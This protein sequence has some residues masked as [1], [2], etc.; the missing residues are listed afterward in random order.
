[1]SAERAGDIIES[2]IGLAVDRR[3]WWFVGTLMRLS[4]QWE[5]NEE[6]VFDPAIKTKIGPSKDWATTYD[7]YIRPDGSNVWD[8][9]PPFNL[10]ARGTALKL[11]WADDSGNGGEIDVSIAELQRQAHFLVEENR[12][13]LTTE[14]K[15]LLQRVLS[16]CAE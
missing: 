2:L 6:G 16:P 10:P 5:A 3:R 13:V 7:D 8:G 15:S 14:R 9:D 12:I 1:M 11:P 4:A